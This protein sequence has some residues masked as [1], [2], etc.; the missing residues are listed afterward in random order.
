MTDYIQFDITESIVTSKLHFFSDKVFRIINFAF[1]SQII[2]LVNLVHSFVNFWFYEEER[3]ESK[4][5]ILSGNMSHLVTVYDPIIHLLH[6]EC[7]KFALLFKY[8]KTKAGSGPFASSYHCSFTESMGQ[9]RVFYLSQFITHSSV[10]C[11]GAFNC[12]F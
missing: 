10:H 11:R 5:I 9:N 1:S 8:L 6:P 12:H 3:E 7:I 4:Y 2:H